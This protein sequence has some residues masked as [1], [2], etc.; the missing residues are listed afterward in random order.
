MNEMK[1]HKNKFG[2]NNRNFIKL[3]FTRN[4]N[5]LKANRKHL[6]RKLSCME[7]YGYYLFSST[8]QVTEIVSLTVHNTIIWGGG[9]LEKDPIGQCRPQ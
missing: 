7:K 8:L 6:Y 5:C 9:V 4:Q 3:T 2:I 1:G